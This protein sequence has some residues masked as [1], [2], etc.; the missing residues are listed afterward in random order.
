MGFGNSTEVEAN[1]T[2]SELM[3]KIST[4]FNLKLVDETK[5]CLKHLRNRL[6]T[7]SRQTIEQI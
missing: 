6:L 7:N 4:F 1:E 2:T 5:R 3:I